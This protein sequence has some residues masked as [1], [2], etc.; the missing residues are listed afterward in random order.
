MAGFAGFIFFGK[1]VSVS[2]MGEFNGGLFKW[3]IGFHVVNDDKVCTCFGCSSCSILSFCHDIGA[4]KN[5][6]A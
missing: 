2:V 6:H 4:I 1:C 3:A 5:H